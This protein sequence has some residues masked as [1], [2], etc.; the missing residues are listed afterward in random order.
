[1][2]LVME[3]CKAIMKKQLKEGEQHEES[4]DRRVKAQQL[5]AEAV[6]D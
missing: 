2:V 1:M 4:E 6:N 3:H 5:R